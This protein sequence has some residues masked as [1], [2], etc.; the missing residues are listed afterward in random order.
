MIN[1][2]IN[3]TRPFI[4]VFLPR[5]G[6]K[7][8]I[9]GTGLPLNMGMHKRAAIKYWKRYLSDLPMLCIVLAPSASA[10]IWT[11]IVTIRSWKKCTFLSPLP[12]TDALDYIFQV[13]SPL[14][15]S[16]FRIFHQTKQGLRH[17]TKVLCFF[18]FFSS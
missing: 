9:P 10:D 16:Y 13:S 12:V 1:E 6:S 8:P 4:A 11:T 14:L 15:S 5:S 18:L 3:A 17:G 2:A 7:G